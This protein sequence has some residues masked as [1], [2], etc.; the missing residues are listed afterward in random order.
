[1]STNGTLQTDKCPDLTEEK[2]WI[3]V[4]CTI[5]NTILAIVTLCY[6]NVWWKRK[7]RKN[8]EKKENASKISNVL[9][10]NYDQTKSTFGNFN[11]NVVK[12]RENKISGGVTEFD[13]LIYMCHPDNVRNYTQREE[14]CQG[15]TVE[16]VMLDVDNIMKLFIE[17]N[18]QLPGIGDR[19]CPEDIKAEFSTDITE[20]GE[21]IFPFV[22]KSRQTMIIQVLKYF[23][24]EQKNHVLVHA[25]ASLVGCE[26]VVVVQAGT[27]IPKD[28]RYQVHKIHLVEFL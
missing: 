8:D 24:N 26:N 23:D 19:I 17:L 12:L 16:N 10:Q 21:A 9:S 7:E 5:V 22:S 15:Y 2:A 6:V 18:L 4:I 28:H 1:M 14:Q 20:M 3:Y 11:N 25:N 13:V 27:K